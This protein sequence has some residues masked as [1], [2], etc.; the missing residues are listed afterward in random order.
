LVASTAADGSQPAVLGYVPY[1]DLCEE[2]GLAQLTRATRHAITRVSPPRAVFPAAPVD[3]SGAISQRLDRRSGNRG[4]PSN[5]PE[6]WWGEPSSTPELYAVHLH[7]AVCIGGRIRHVSRHWHV[8]GQLIVVDDR[9][10]VDDSFYVRD[11]ARALPR[12]LLTEGASGYT[13]HAA[14]DGVPT[15]RGLHVLVGSVHGQLGHFLLEG[16]S[17]LWLLDRI[18]LDDAR[19]VV[20][21]PELHPWQVPVLAAAG[22]PVERIEHVREPTRFEHLV[23]PARATNLHRA[24]SPEQDAVWDRIARRSR[25]RARA[26]R[27]TSRARVGETSQPRRRRRSPPPGPAGE[28]R[29]ADATTSRTPL[30]PSQSCGAASPR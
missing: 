14:I 10:L 17:R 7:D 4:G 24:S 25:A 13:S 20:Y 8:S 26:R 12:D 18:A 23:V 16:L 22:V 15:R 6:T 2:V 5:V 9:H 28:H 11:H 21:E 27:Y 3:L 1:T 29:D 19:F 30:V